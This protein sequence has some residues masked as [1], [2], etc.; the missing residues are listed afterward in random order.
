MYS[1]IYMHI[2]VYIVY[3][4]PLRIPCLYILCIGLRSTPSHV[5]ICPY[6]AYPVPPTYMPACLPFSQCQKKD[7]KKILGMPKIIYI[8]SHTPASLPFLP[9]IFFF[10]YL[11]IGFTYLPAFLRSFL[12]CLCH[13][14][15]FWNE[16][17]S[18]SF[19]NI[20]A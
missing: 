17:Q 8:Y 16:D 10:T 5:F 4:Y 20:R 2:C 13:A 6:M 18:V 3:M 12:P 11:Y 9:F 1:S 14:L 19:Q 7:Q 15:I